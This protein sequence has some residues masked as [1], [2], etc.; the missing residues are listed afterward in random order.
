V[1]GSAPW[2]VGSAGWNIPRAHRERF[3]PE[4]S[5]LQR[6]AARLNAVEINSSFYRSHSAATYER[7]AASVPPAFRF[8]VKLPKLITH[9]R[10]LARAREPLLAFLDQVAGLGGKIG[11]LLVQLPPSFAF[12]PRRVGRFFDLIRRFYAGPVVC[13]PRH[14]TWTT[15]AAVRGLQ[16]SCIGRVA[17]DPPRADGLGEPS[18]TGPVYYRWHG[19]PR[20]YFSP[21]TA[22]VLERLA[23]KMAAGGAGSWCI[24]DN[25]G[26]GA[27]AENALDLTARL[28]A[29]VTSAAAARSSPCEPLRR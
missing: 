18:G 28:R 7:W 8:A 17:A 29:K 10:G 1:S 19:S 20:V 14:H 4:G 2:F 11:P 3:A 12:E 22:S 5:Q 9:D 25:T 21:Y 15:A 13:E 26:S 23:D 6:Y 27:A 16:A 24:F